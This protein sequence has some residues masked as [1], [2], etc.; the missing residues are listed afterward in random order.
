MSKPTEGEGARRHEPFCPDLRA[1]AVIRAGDEDEATPLASAEALRDAAPHTA[2]M[3]TV[4]QPQVVTERCCASSR[5][6]R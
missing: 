6:R 3:P 4:E 5:G 2:H 1:P